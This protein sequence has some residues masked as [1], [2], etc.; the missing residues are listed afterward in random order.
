MS[1]F[2]KNKHSLCSDVSDSSLWGNLNIHIP[3]RTLQENS[4][5]H[6]S[7]GTTHMQ[8]STHAYTHTPRVVRARGKIRGAANGDGQLGCCFIKVQKEMQI[9]VLQD[10]IGS[11]SF[12]LPTLKRQTERRRHQRGFG[13]LHHQVKKW[14]EKK[15]WLLSASLST[16]NIYSLSRSGVAPPVG[17]LNT[18]P[19][20]IASSSWLPR[21]E[22]QMIFLVWFIA[23][24]AN[25][26]RRK[27]FFSISCLKWAEC[28]PGCTSYLKFGWPYSWAPR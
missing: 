12:R 21:D 9:C 2:P 26:L 15:R 14:K 16:R 1:S 17:S 27:V 6:P 19:G 18:S 22:L 7:R 25:V 3:R 4:H 5:S 28:G 10:A 8:T 11:A 13:S 20:L 24:S 23:R